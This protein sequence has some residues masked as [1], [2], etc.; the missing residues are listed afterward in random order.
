MSAPGNGCNAQHFKLLICLAM[1]PHI[2]VTD[3]LSF[4]FFFCTNSLSLP[5]RLLGFSSF[6]ATAPISFWSNLPV[7]LTLCWCFTNSGPLDSLR[8]IG[9][10]VYLFFDVFNGPFDDTLGKDFGIGHIE[11]ELYNILYSKRLFRQ[12]HGL[13]CRQIWTL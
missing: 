1:E 3:L 2:K 12:F 10:L 6:F 8:D 9:T 11:P 13:R 4:F 5:V 7:V